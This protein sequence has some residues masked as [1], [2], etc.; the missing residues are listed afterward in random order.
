MCGMCGVMTF[1]GVPPSR[2]LVQA[3]T[4]SLAHR[5]PDAEGVVILPPPACVGLGHRR[6]AII[7]LSPGGVQPMTNED[8]T[9]WISFNGEIYNYRELRRSLEARHP[10]KSQSDTEVMLHLYEERGP[11]FVED[12]AGMFALALWDGR[13]RRLVLA[14]DR[15]GKKP[16]YWTRTPSALVFGSEVKALLRH[17]GVSRDIAPEHLPHFF[18]L[19]HPPTGQTLYRGIFQLAPATVMTVETDGRVAQ[20][21]YWRPAMRPVQPAPTF[22][23]A[24]AAV[25]ALVTDAVEQRL[26]ADVP[27]GAF[28]SGGIDSNVVVGVMSRV[29]GPP[30]QTFTLGF[31]GDPSLDETSRAREAARHFGTKHTEFIVEPGAVDLV[32]ALVRHHDGP[33]GDSSAIPTYI[34]SELARQHVTVALNGD[35]GDEV[36]GGYLRFRAA[37]AAD[38][39][40]AT[41]ARLAHR[42]LGAF[43]EP[44]EYH[45]WIRRTRRFAAA[46]SDPLEA[47]MRRWISIFTDDLRELLQPEPAAHVASAEAYPRELVAECE[48]A[49]PLG[50]LLYLNFLTY[51]PDDLLVKMD[52]CSMAHALEVRS[53]LLDHRLVDYAMALPDEMKLRGF[54]SKRILRAAFAD[55]LPAAVTSGPKRG[56]GVPIGAWFRGPLRAYVRDHLDNPSARLAA[57]VRPAYVA[58]LL[59]E[60]ARGVRDHGARLWTLLTFEAWLRRVEAPGW[61]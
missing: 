10:F 20:R 5:G 14:R 15:V 11:A 13:A 39:V 28:L 36:F 43:P 32:D 58:R 31:T 27:V 60:H 23:D 42:A 47:R 9:L 52:R 50:R 24:C 55:L 12:L 59:D 26:V 57:W 4:D 44:A 22:P 25:R 30:V 48:G 8:E 6:L 21:R 35:G 7:D 61:Q 53:P 3:M 56:F 17:P 40:P 19:G 34:V 37:L 45:H 38:R 18:A 2:G 29:V 49:T 54:E 41:I 33:F 46:V 1:D 16:L 51:L